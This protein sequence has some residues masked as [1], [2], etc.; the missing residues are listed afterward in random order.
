M[1]VTGPVPLQAPCEAL[2]ETKLTPDG[3]LSVTFKLVAAAGPLLVTRMRYDKL[4]PAWAGF[5]DADFVTARSTLE[6]LITRN[7]T[8]VVLIKLPDVP[9]TVIMLLASGVAAPVVIVNVD[10]FD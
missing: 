7:I 2:A 9:V 3:K 1:Q 4:R 8:C 5:G 6:A 10:V